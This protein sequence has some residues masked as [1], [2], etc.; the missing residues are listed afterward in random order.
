MTI[1]M[2]SSLDTG[3]P[4]LS[5]TYFNRL[6][7]ILTACLVSGYG[8]KPGAGWTITHSHDQGVAYSNGEGNAYFSY[9]DDTQRTNAGIIETI[10]DSSSKT[11]V[12]DNA[13]QAS[14]GL[15]ASGGNLSGTNTHWVVV[16]DEKTCIVMFGGGFTGADST[17]TGSGA[18][19][20]PLYFGRYINALGL[21]PAFCLLGW[22]ENA[23]PWTGRLGMVTDNVCGR[24]LR[25][26]FTGLVDQGA[27]PKYA[28]GTYSPAEALAVK[29]HVPQQSRLMPFR[30]PIMGMGA[31]ISGGTTR[32]GAR[33]VG[34][35]RGIIMESSLNSSLLSKVLAMF[36]KADTWQGRVQ[37]IEVAPGKLWV[38]F[39]SGPRDMGYFIS[40]DPADWE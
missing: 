39:W 11:P 33:P 5:G 28:L 15:T 14:D 7:Q 24:M 32:A 37:T 27:T 26:P 20:M 1:R 8:A 16:A 13:Y 18:Q 25:N 12:G 40:L 21:S 31:G 34:W 23:T 35:P 10:T 9:Q 30:P 29:T 3:A 4:A 6:R 19:A 36:G 17:Y 2:Y 22:T 38:P